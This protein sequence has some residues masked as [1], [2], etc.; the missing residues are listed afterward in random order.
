MKRNSCSSRILMLLYLHKFCPKIAQLFVRT[1]LLF[2]SSEKTA[3][4]TLA[5][6]QYQNLLISP[7]RAATANFCQARAPQLWPHQRCAAPATTAFYSAKS[8][9]GLGLGGLASCG[10][11]VKYE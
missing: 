7:F 11:P 4:L 6:V 8:R 3:I 9:Q 1:S 2:I 10:G 5:L